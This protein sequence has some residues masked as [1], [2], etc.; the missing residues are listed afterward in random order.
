MLARF[1]AKQLGDPSGPFG[2]L[3][4]SRLLNRGNDEL[5]SATLTALAL[6]PRDRYLDLGFGGGVSF[7]K[8]G[9]VV[10]EPMRGVDPSSDMIATVN[11][12]LAP[13]VRAGRLSLRLGTAADPGVE[14]GSVDRLLTA[15]TIYFWPGLPA[16]L[17]GCLRVLAPGGRLA[18]GLTQRQ[19]MKQFA[20]TEHGFTK[21][22]GTE[23]IGPL[24]RAGFENVHVHRLYSR[25]TE[26]DAVVTAT[27]PL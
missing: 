20:F 6:A 13:L 7:E 18:L 27:K 26:G 19:K 24:E 1:V 17:A 12:R 25:V 15:N 21:Y 4:M 9:R 11:E 23:L 8:A 10:T 14:P 2:K 3:V 22:E 5:I 16:G